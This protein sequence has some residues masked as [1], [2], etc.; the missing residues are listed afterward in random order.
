MK[1]SFLIAIV[2]I[3]FTF[4]RCSKD[5]KPEPAVPDDPY[6]LVWSDEFDYTGLPDSTK[7]SYD[8]GAGGWGNDEAEYYTS[9]RL[10]NSEVRD[11]FLFINAIKE[12]FEGKKY[13]SARLVT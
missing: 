10:K 6:Q 3:A 13:T 9:S 1:Q 2:L 11:G 7:W 4:W 12:D 8:K 5:K